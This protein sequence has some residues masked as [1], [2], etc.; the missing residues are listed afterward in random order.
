VSF[1]PLARARD[2]AC[3]VVRRA[4]HWRGRATLFLGKVG[5]D[6]RKPDRLVVVTKDDL[7]EV[8]LRLELIF[9]SRGTLFGGK[10]NRSPRELI[11]L[12][13]A[14]ALLFTKFAVSSTRYPTRA[15]VGRKPG[16]AL[17]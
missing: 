1:Y 7:P 17:Q 12:G 13:R 15:P 14:A 2:S 11:P 16:P 6:L 5:A 8:L 9:G 3:G 4:A 10:L